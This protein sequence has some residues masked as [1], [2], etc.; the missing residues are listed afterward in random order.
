MVP[1]VFPPRDLLGSG[2]QPL[3]NSQLREP[4]FTPHLIDQRGDVLARL[5]QVGRLFRGAAGVGCAAL[6]PHRVVPIDVE[7]QGLAHICQ[8]HIVIAVDEVC[9][10]L[11]LLPIQIELVG[12]ADRRQDFL[13]RV[14][15]RARQG[16]AQDDAR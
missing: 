16:H 10:Q 14:R 3:V 8:F 13:R 11:D 1:G 6:N 5:L 4:V 2:H 7:V 12:A 9:L 15:R